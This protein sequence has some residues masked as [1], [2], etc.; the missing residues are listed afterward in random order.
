MRN[1][2]VKR[3]CSTVLI[4]VII[5]STVLAGV[6]GSFAAGVDKPTPKSLPV[7]TVLIGRYILCLQTMTVELYEAAKKSAEDSDQRQIFYKSEFAS[8]AWIDITNSDELS[9]ITTA[10]KSAVVD[11]VVKPII[12]TALFWAKE[13]GTV[14]DLLS[15]N[16]VV[17]SNTKD[18]ND[19]SK[20]SEMDG[21]LTRKDMLAEM[22]DESDDDSTDEEKADVSA[23]LA[24]RGSIA[25]V[26]NP[27]DF[28]MVGN[29]EE[30]A[31]S[32]SAKKIAADINKL[33]QYA[34]QLIEKKEPNKIV[35]IIHQM[36]RQ[37]DIER[38]LLVYQELFDRLSNELKFAVQKNYAD[39]IADYG[40]ALD[41]VNTK[42]RE[43]ADALSALEG[44]GRLEKAKAA[45]VKKLQNGILADTAAEEKNAAGQNDENSDKED[46]LRKIKNLND[47]LDNSIV[48]KVGESITLTPVYDQ[49][50]R[51][52]LKACAAAEESTYQKAKREGELRPVLNGLIEK[53]VLAIKEIG[54][55]AQTLLS[56]LVERTT[57]E[58]KL[59][60]LYENA[61]DLIRDQNAALPANDFKR[62]TADMMQ[63]FLDAIETKLASVLAKRLVNQNPDAQSLNGLQEEVKQLLNGKYLEALSNANTALAEEIKR[64]LDELNAQIALLEDAAMQTYVALIRERAALEDERSQALNGTGAAKGKRTDVGAIQTDLDAVNAKL[65]AY[66]STLDGETAKMIGAYLEKAGTFLEAVR[67]RDFQTAEAHAQELKT[68]I[69]MLPEEM[70]GKNGLLDLKNILDWMYV[71]AAADYDVT[72]AKAIGQLINS[73][74]GAEELINIAALA[75]LLNSAALSE[76]EKKELDSLLK[77]LEKE[78]D[79]GGVSHNT[80]DALRGIQKKHEALL[81]GNGAQ[82]N[83]AADRESAHDGE[84]I[85]EMVD[86]NGEIVIPPNTSAAATYAKLIED[87][88]GNAFMNG[89]GVVGDSTADYRAENTRLMVY[90][91]MRENAKFFGM[92]TDID[93]RIA[94]IIPAITGLESEK[95]DKE[96]MAQ[97]R[98]RKEAAFGETRNISEIELG[99]IAV[100]GVTV[101]LSLPPLLQ[102]GEVLYPIRDFYQAFGYTLGW[103]TNGQI[104]TVSGQNNESM[105]FYIGSDILSRNGS[106][107]TM[108]TY[109]RL[110]GDKAYAPLYDMAKTVDAELYWF[111]QADFGVVYARSRLLLIQ[112]KIS[113]IA[114]RYSR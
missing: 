20:L 105:R 80:L 113:E 2:K 42:L 49:A 89:Q 52:F 63:T 36:I 98:M 77:A 106:D 97:I 68:I 71:R 95:Y 79:N 64:Q 76:L 65:A 88:L 16:P 86:G 27:L 39:L 56:Y 9:A 55:E 40:T 48:D 78:L 112:Q 96:T 21:I 53:R 82:T 66:L 33:A 99:N 107:E 70:T 57:E 62:A 72:T 87:A 54:E 93:K 38:S 5:F 6:P 103:E 101:K 13:D 58:A 84:G 108:K 43:L 23:V 110:L 47:I 15:G 102:N 31:R 12:D 100:D 85:I 10:T 8:G 83:A 41:S 4:L 19:V 25:R 22:P 109:A 67:A 94:E 34:Q 44:S 111:A 3:Y 28:I 61:R 37:C 1:R 14:T 32:K 81:D 30:S 114:E 73:I 7:G 46:L 51:D 60:S 91:L 17:L 35:E 59:Q 74:Y 69:S 24:K 104:V 26:L 45:Y 18:Y 75:A 11:T 92:V 29:T 90:R 50:M